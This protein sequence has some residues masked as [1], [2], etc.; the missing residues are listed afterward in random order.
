MVSSVSAYSLLAESFTKRYGRAPEVMVRAPGRLNLVGEHT[1]YNEGFVLPIAVDREVVVAAS[2]G[3]GTRVRVYTASYDDSDSFDSESVDVNP[4]TMWVNYVRG[5]F[6]FLGETV[7]VSGADIYIEGGVPIGAGM[8][9]SAALEVSVAKALQGLYEFDM[10]PVEMAVLCQ[11]A[12]HEFAGTKCGIMDQFISLLAEKDHALLIDC[13]TL[14]SEQ[15]RVPFQDVAVVVCDTKIKHEL[16]SS[17]YNTR[18]RECEEAVEI[19][20]VDLPEIRTLRDVSADD[21]TRVQ[22]DLPEALLR[23]ARHVITENDRVGQ[24]AGLLMAGEVA[25]FGDVLYRSHASLRDDYEVSC[26]ELDLLV[27]LARG[28]P[29]VYG[30]RM[31]GGGFGGSTLSLV[32]SSRVGSFSQTVND[33]YTEQFGYSPGVYVCST[34]D[35]AS[36]VEF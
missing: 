25:A 10:R 14:D 28:H 34:A 35:G 8:S 31:T 24:G 2:R 5:V 3:E 9:S 32:E 22:F 21:L 17:E 7:G 36:E 18:R 19:M 27:E 11:K 16:A 12:E 26:P 13:R 4:D 33:T 30:S 15:I 23:R 29:G 20:R 1:D 6:Y